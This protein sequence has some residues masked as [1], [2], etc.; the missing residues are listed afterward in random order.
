MDQ[1]GNAGGDGFSIAS[2]F[3]GVERG[4]GPGRR[5]SEFSRA[6]EEGELTGEQFLFVKAIEEFKRGNNKTY[7]SWTDV[8]E[9][10][11]LLGYRKTVASEL[12]IRGADDF[13]ERADARSNVR[14]RGWEK[15]FEPKGKRAA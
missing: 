12:A 14:P 15:R 6:A 1:Q 7:P 5:L 2:G 13:V 4:R 8:L 9:V 3:T 10:V 11:R